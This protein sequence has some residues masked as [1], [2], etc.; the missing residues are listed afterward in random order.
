MKMVF[1][2]KPQ[3]VYTGAAKPPP[4][5]TPVSLGII[6]YTTRNGCPCRDHLQKEIK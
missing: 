3:N 2:I 5:P 6:Y 1:S 4:A